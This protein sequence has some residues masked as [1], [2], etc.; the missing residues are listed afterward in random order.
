MKSFL[1]NFSLFILIVGSVAF[2]LSTLSDYA[3]KQREN[4]FLKISRNIDKVFTGDSNIES[5]VND[6][7]IPNSLNIA[8]SGEAYMYTYAKIKSLLEYNNQIK[9]IYIGFSFWDLIEYTEEL[10]LF[11]NK[12]AIE[13]IALYNYLLNYYDKSVLIKNNP[14]AYIR[15]VLKSILS[16]YQ[17]FKRSFHREGF[18]GRLI[19][20]G[21]YENSG[22]DK[23]QEDIKINPFK[24]QVFE[25]G[26]FQIEYLKKISELCKQKSI[27]LVLLNTPK[28][29]YYYSNVPEAIRQN[30]ISVRKSLSRDSL[31]DLS[32]FSFPDSCFGDLTHLNSIGARRFSEYLNEK[33]R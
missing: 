32:T 7:I 12:F 18:N 13:K 23:L 16:N 15:G 9:T 33:I 20:F 6:S 19:N 31:L 26:L 10:W 8:Q 11:S 30:W 4:S 22:R 1:I 24:E 2:G 5:A 25:E 27:K 17:V 29:I 21:G 28:H 14:K 3:I